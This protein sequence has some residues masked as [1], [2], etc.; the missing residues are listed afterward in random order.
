VVCKVAAVA[1]T[2]CCTAAT[3]LGAQQNGGLQW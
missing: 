3:E 1:A 2:L